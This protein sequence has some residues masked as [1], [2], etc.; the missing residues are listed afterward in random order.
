MSP[1]SGPRVSLW[2]QHW[3]DQSSM[4]ELLEP[5][6]LTEQ[7][8]LHQVETHYI[9][10]AGGWVGLRWRIPRSCSRH[11]AAIFRLQPAAPATISPGDDKNDNGAPSGQEDVRDRIRRRIAQHRD[12]A[13]RAFLDGGHR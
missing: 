11:Q 10:L 5:H 3:M 12:R 4:D 8:A 1:G 13:P 2:G 9:L 7:V 6:W